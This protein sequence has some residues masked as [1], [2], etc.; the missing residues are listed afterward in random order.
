MAKSGSTSVAITSWDTLKFSWEITSQSIAN[1]TSTV[2][3]KLQLIAG[4]SGRISSSAPKS[5]EVKVDGKT[6]SG[7]NYIGISNNQTKTLASDST[8][9]THN[10]DGKK[11]FSYSFTQQIAVTFSGTYI[12][13]KSGSGT[14]TL[15]TIARASSLS[16]SNGTLG[17][18]LALKVTKQDSSFTHTITYKCGSVSGTVCTKSSSASVAWN[19]STGNTLNLAKQN[20][21]GTTVSVTFTLTTYS[22]NTAI[23]SAVTKTV[24]MTIPASVKPS[25]SVKIEDKTT[26]KIDD[27]THSVVDF[28]GSSVKGLSKLTVTIDP[29]LAQNSPIKSWKTTI[30]GVTYTKDSFT[31]GALN[32]SGSIKVTSTVTDSRKRSGT[33]DPATVSVLDYNP[34]VISKLNVGRCDD[35]NGETKGADNDEGEW[36]KVTVSA[37]ITPLND[38]NTTKYEIRYKPSSG[39]DYIS[40]ELS[41]AADASKYSVE[42][43][44]FYFLADSGSSYDV[45]FVVSDNHNETHR[46]TTVST[47]FTLMHFGIDGTSMGIGKVSELENVLDIGMQTRHYGGLMHPVLPKETDLN[48]IRTPN[49]YVGADLK[50]NNYVCGDE[51]LPLNS[52][53]FSLEVVGMGVEGQ[54]KQRLTYCQMN[55]SRAWERIYHSVNGEMKWGKWICVSDFDGQLLW[56]GAYYMNETQTATLS[57]PISK[58]RSG[59]VLIFSRYSGG[60]A[61]DYH[62]NSYFIPKYQV[63][64]HPGAGCVFVMSTKEPFST[65][66]SK[67]LY[68][69]DQTIVGSDVNQAVGTAN[70][71]TYSN[72]GFVLRHVIGV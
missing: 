1:N 12:A 55:L 48:E 56:D 20:T 62:F 22:G 52:G 40:K 7:T 25:C 32:S 64:L 42:E 50:T 61:Q 39:S 34:P 57:E 54:V 29:T 67:Y 46:A 6:Y 44:E 68:I 4:S 59:I 45:E 19:T 71:V 9:I 26:F 36:V 10:P 43:H 17:T 49:T 23:G 24:T 13:S 37:T 63:S 38:L 14:G 27:E 58:Q 41:I 72:N 35:P 2:S 18:S 16:V 47:A 69:N 53:T 31:T 51:A 28:Y 15:D 70:G 30:D 33:S 60:E 3:W 11:T 65:V 66:G 5:W 8:V 21:T